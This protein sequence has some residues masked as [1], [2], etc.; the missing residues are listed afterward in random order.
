MRNILFIALQ[1]LLF[2]FQASTWAQMPAIHDQQFRKKLA[3]QHNTQ[4]TVFI[5]YN[6]GNC[7][8]YVDEFIYNLNITNKKKK[9][10]FIVDYK[11]LNY[12]KNYL[13]ESEY[14]Q[15]N[16][17]IFIDSRLFN[18]YH[19]NLPFAFYFKNHNIITVQG[20]L[21]KILNTKAEALPF[22][23]IPNFSLSPNPNKCAYKNLIS[24]YCEEKNKLFCKV[25]DDY[26]SNMDIDSAE[27]TRIKA[28]RD[29]IALYNVKGYSLISEEMQI[30]NNIQSGIVSYRYMHITKD[31]IFITNKVHLFS[32]DLLNK[33]FTSRDFIFP[34]N[35]EQYAITGMRSIAGMHFAATI[36]PKEKAVL[37]T[38]ND[39]FMICYAE[40]DAD[41]KKNNI[42]VQLINTH[43]DTKEF[44]NITD[45]L[46]LV[47][48]FQRLNDTLLCTQSS[49]KL[50]NLNKKSKPYILPFITENYNNALLFTKKVNNK[51][52]FYTYNYENHLATILTTEDFLSYKIKQITEYIRD[53]VLLDIN[54]EG[55][56]IFIKTTSTYFYLYKIAG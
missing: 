34:E 33:R 37:K 8:V 2:L 52:L 32:L 45:N 27:R 44:L 17:I 49:N 1:T 10:G 12:Y 3:K 7:N 26:Y 47:S 16:K 36:I 5:N 30:S 23:S 55:E 18:D 46:N 43:I 9:F 21:N 54:D 38:A 41:M 29:T 4:N 50:Y 39:S 53:K 13:R 40:F 42:H 19:T 20:T 31:S 25:M 56:L 24:Y 22:D 6:F 28:A 11:Y 15:K 51:Y 14:F 48:I 35:M